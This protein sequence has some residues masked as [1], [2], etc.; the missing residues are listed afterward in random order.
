MMYFEYGCAEMD[1]LSQR[2]ARLG[3]VIEKVGKIER[4]INPDIFAAL[5][6]SIVS[7]QISGKAA[8]TVCSRLAAFLNGITPAALHNSELD[9]IQKCGMSFRKAS[10][11]KGI[12]VAAVDGTVDFSSLPEKSDDEIIRIL[13]S[14]KGVGQWTAEMLLIFSLN[15]KD[16]FS[17]GDLAVKRGLMNL[18]GLNEISKA[19][20]ETYRRLYSPYGSVASLYLWAIS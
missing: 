4:E 10:Y 11:I 3:G 18:Q 19:G 16:I 7:Q 6:E 2:D 20:F 8:I 17:Y 9:D 12:A 1:Y 13:S 15:R 14:L 5:V